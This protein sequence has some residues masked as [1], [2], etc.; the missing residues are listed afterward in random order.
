MDQVQGSRWTKSQPTL[1][2][3][4]TQ[5]PPRAAQAS[6]GSAIPAEQPNSLTCSHGKSHIFG[7]PKPPHT[8]SR[9]SQGR[10]L[11]HCSHPN[12]HQRVGSSPQTSGRP[13]Q[14]SDATVKSHRSHQRSK[15]RSNP[16]HPKPRPAI[17]LFG[18]PHMRVRK[19][20]ALGK[21]LQ[22]ARKI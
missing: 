4:T 11:R 1:T 22:G 13:L 20:W 16:S 15:I 18:R 12:P 8:N 9:C 2:L 6:S 21:I 5:T 19:F 17:V 10:P 3:T 14:G 7:C